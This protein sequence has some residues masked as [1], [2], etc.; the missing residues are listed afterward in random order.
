METDRFNSIRK[1]VFAM[2]EKELAEDCCCKSYEGA[3]EVTAEYPNYFEDEKAISSPCWCCITLHCYVLG[4]AR[5]YD[6]TGKTF[7]EALNKFE[8]QIVQWEAR[9]KNERTD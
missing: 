1:R 2:I 5:H 4:A 9:Y 7:A 8:A 6:F 3:I